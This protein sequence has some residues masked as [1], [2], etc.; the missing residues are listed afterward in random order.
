[1]FITT[2]CPF[3]SIRHTSPKSHYID[4]SIFPLGNA[5]YSLFAKVVFYCLSLLKSD[6]AARTM[7]IAPLLVDGYS[8][9]LY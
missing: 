4:L 5:Q 3:E 8:T 2:I 6:T 9:V 1:M 7:G